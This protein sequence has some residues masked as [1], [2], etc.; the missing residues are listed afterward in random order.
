MSTNENPVERRHYFVD[1]A[2]DP[3]I[4][5]KNRV[6]AGTPGCSSFFLLG[7]LDVRDVEMLN[8]DMDDLSNRLK[9]EPY[10]KRIPSMQPDAKKTAIQFHAKDDAPEVRYEVFRT[11]MAHDIRFYGVIRNKKAVAAY[12]RQRNEREPDYRYPPGELYDT[13]VRRLFHGLLHLGRQYTICFARRGWADHTQS[14][15]S[16]LLSARQDYQEL[17]ASGDDG[18]MQVK[19]FWSSQSRALQATDYFLWALQRLYERNESPQKII[20]RL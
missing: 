14:F 3:Y 15:K 13:L 19:E 8:A 17:S 20:R 7:V 1:E 18:E 11:L 2:G 9:A 6:V 10:L 4:T 12:I 16:A 5:K